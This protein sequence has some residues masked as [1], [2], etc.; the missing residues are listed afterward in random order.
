MNPIRIMHI[1]PDLVPYGL[2]RVV[3]TLALLGDRRHFEISVVSLYGHMPGSL[4]NELRDAGIQ[5]FHLNKRKG[6]DIRMFGRLARVMRKV[7]PH[8]LHTHNYVLRYV[9]PAAAVAGHPQILHTVHNV[10][11]RETDRLGVWIQKHA[12]RGRVQ[13]VTI[14]EECSTSFERVYGQVAPMVRN[15]ITVD[16][17]ARPAISRA[18]WRASEG[19]DTSDILITCVARFDEQKNHQA[20][21]EAFA[22][23]AGLVPNAKLILSGN[24]RLQPE[25]EN[26]V[27]RRGLRDRVFFLGRRDDVPALL[28]ASDIFALASLWEGNP[29]SVMEALAAGLPLAGTRVGAIPEL[30]SDGIH[31]ILSAPGDIRALANAMTHLAFDERARRTMGRAAAQ[32]ARDRFDHRQ[33]VDAYQNL[34]RK[35]MRLEVHEGELLCQ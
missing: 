5:V 10:A 14:S 18:A 8:I 20:L 26:L 34:Y 32:R 17:Y 1:L 12:F 35:L 3:A 4:T 22:Q 21:V 27:Q 29:L 25:I 30:A 24:G 9:L 15:G 6:L 19:F 23:T 31:G 13:P 16:H 33:M 28:G 7:R 2:E 11:D